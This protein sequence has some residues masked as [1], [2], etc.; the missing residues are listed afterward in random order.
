MGT[1]LNHKWHI[2]KSQAHLGVAAACR[3]THDSHFTEPDDPEP[4]IPPPE[5]GEALSH[6]LWLRN[7]LDWHTHRNKSSGPGRQRGREHVGLLFAPCY[8]W[9]GVHSWL[10]LHWDH[11][12][13]ILV[14]EGSCD[15]VPQRWEL[16][17][18]GVNSFT[19]WKLEV[20]HQ[21]ARSGGILPGLF[22]LLGALGSPWLLV[23]AQP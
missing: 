16:R 18:P 17:T 22:W 10:A 11:L 19:V 20:S 13:C 6:H 9:G 23:V 7:A 8:L 4:I 1:N 15:K 14:S 21:G 12:P 3:E 5:L 2:I